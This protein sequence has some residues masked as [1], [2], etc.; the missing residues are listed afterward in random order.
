MIS[1]MHVVVTLAHP[2]LSG[3]GF[4]YLP[5]NALFTGKG[6]HFVAAQKARN[7]AG[8]TPA[9]VAVARH[10]TFS[11]LLSSLWGSP[12]SAACRGIYEFASI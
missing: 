2:S 4:S 8:A 10:N 5:R 11:S 1:A 3:C 7:F 6:G 9:F 12:Q